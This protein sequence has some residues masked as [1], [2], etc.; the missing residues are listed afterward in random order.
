MNKIKT[1]I[2]THKLVSIIIASVLVVGITLSIVL[3]LT[4]RHKHTY[5][6][7]WSTNAASHWHECTGKKC[8]KAKDNAEHT[9]IDKNNDTQYWLECSVCGYQQEK[10]EATLANATHYANAMNL[11]D[12]EGNYYKNFDMIVMEGIQAS[13]KTRAYQYT[14]TETA[15]YKYSTASDAD[16]ETIWINENGKGVIYTKHD[17][18]SNWVRTEQENEFTDFAS[19]FTST[20]IS[21]VPTLVPF[22]TISSEYNSETRTGYNKNFNMYYGEMVYGST[23]RRY[24]MKF[25]DGKLI[26][27]DLL[28]KNKTTNDLIFRYDTRITYGNATIQ[29]PSGKDVATT[30]SYNESTHNFLLSDVSLKAG[31]TKWFLLDIT[32]EIYDT[33]RTSDETGLE[34]VGEFTPSA[35][36]ATLTLTI[37]AEDFTGIQITNEATELGKMNF[38]GFRAGTYYVKI[39]ANENCTGSL[40]I[41]FAN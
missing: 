30:M 21:N 1:W 27:M 38:K 31:E 9:F 20:F 16:L 12:S 5:S 26:W 23:N 8:D 40:N 3:P 18:E 14:V 6:E 13:N 11:K 32:S 10:I 2:I 19:C 37:E 22:D 24:S 33:N 41:G 29:I 34:V 36:S 28:I 4:L 15:A 17:A 7:E 39:T 35:I 25:G